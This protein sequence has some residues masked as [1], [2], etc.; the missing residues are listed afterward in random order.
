MAPSRIHWSPPPNWNACRRELIIA[1]DLVAA[2]IFAQ[3]FLDYWLAGLMSQLQQSPIVL[4]LS[5]VPDR[6]K[7]SLLLTS[8]MAVLI[9]YRMTSGDRL[10]VDRGMFV[11][12]C[13][14]VSGFASDKLKIVFGRLPPDALLIDGAYGFNFFS[15]GSGFDS[16]PSSHAAMAAGIAGAVCV[17]WPAHHRIFIT[18]A[19]VV[20]A[21]RFI[22]GVHFVSDV[23]IGGAVGLGIAA[24]MQIVFHHC[25][26]EIGSPSSA[27]K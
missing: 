5:L 15:S 26:I 2:C 25:G 6:V 27:T 7:L 10:R 24:L 18:A 13:G 1:L 8:L 16:F 19:V 4:A 3:L 9:A 21:S 12:G 20:A 17:I 14:V 22:T 23:L 11:L